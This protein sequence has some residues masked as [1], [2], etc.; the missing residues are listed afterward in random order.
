MER[1]TFTL[2][3]GFR[4]SGKTT[5]I[6][7]VIAGWVLF[8]LAITLLDLR[9]CL[10]LLDAQL[11]DLRRKLAQKHTDVPALNYTGTVILTPERPRT[12]ASAPSPHRDFQTENT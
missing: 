3:Q 9:S 6:L 2:I 8:L 4:A 7:S 11:C 1:E 10:L 12:D 5:L